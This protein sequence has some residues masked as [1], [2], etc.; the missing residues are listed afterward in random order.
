MART[1][2]VIGGAGGIGW[3]LARRLSAEGWGLHLIGR[4]QASLEAAAEE[5]G[6]SWAV[7]DVRDAS[8]LSAAVA[9]APGPV[10]GLAYAVGTITLK[11][12]GRVSA[13]DARSDFEINA[14]GA[15]TAIQAAL[16]ALKA[17]GGSVVLFSSV[18]VGQGFAN[19][20]SI[21]MAKGAVEGL[22]RAL[23][24]ELAPKVRVNCVAPSLTQTPLAAPLTSN[25]QMAGAIAALHPM[26]RLGTPEDI[27]AAAAFLLGD[28]AGWMTGQVLGVDGGRSTLRT[29]G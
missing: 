8:A 13:E 16:P 26:Q 1:A 20:A 18:A 6:G 12:L 28:D 19:H 24:T 9:A 17:E 23:A 5:V 27:A 2:I 25:A 21:A 10:G 29:K 15:M 11:P 7:A 3:A 22:T 4:T 14:L